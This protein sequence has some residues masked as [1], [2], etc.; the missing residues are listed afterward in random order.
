MLFDSSFHTDFLEY[1][2]QGFSMSYFMDVSTTICSLQFIREIR[3]L[4][5][6]SDFV[7]NKFTLLKNY[8]A[9]RK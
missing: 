3:N 1:K 2:D 7:S 4:E 6:E 9:D 5:Y 8:F